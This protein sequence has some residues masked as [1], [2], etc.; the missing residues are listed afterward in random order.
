[1]NSAAVGLIMWERRHAVRAS[2]PGRT[3]CGIRTGLADVGDV[4]GLM[5]FA[6]AG[7]SGFR[8]CA[9]CLPMWRRVVALKGIGSSSEIAGDTRTYRDGMDI[10]GRSG[11][12][13]VR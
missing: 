8:P 2:H 10:I 11:A 9:R 7:E 13:A 12:A 3:L 4:P 6:G 5:D 1:M